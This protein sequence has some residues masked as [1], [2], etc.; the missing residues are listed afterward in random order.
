MCDQGTFSFMQYFVYVRRLNAHVA[1]YFVS[2]VLHLSYIP[3][4]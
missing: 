3:V 1:V 4:P 2:I